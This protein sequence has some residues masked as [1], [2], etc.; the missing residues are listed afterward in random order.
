MAAR[1]SINPVTVNVCKKVRTT[2]FRQI[3][4][5]YQ[6]LTVNLD[7]ELKSLSFCKAE[8]DFFFLHFLLFFEISKYFFIFEKSLLEMYYIS[9]FFNK[10]QV[11]TISL[12]G[13]TSLRRLIRF[14][15]QFTK[16]HKVQYK[17]Y[18]ESLEILIPAKASSIVVVGSQFRSRDS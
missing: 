5:Q 8:T 18:T 6:V 13:G 14:R 17:A 16:Q 2:F 4:I 10:K 15:N 1:S 3:N 9:L 12:Q 7:V 11:D